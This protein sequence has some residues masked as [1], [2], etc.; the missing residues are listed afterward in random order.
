MNI[1]QFDHVDLGTFDISINLDTTDQEISFF[2][3]FFTINRYD[4]TTLSFSETIDDAAANNISLGNIVRFDSKAVTA[5]GG[6]SIEVITI[7]STYRSA[8]IHAL[9]VD[10]ETGEAFGTEVNLINDGSEVLSVFINTVE[11]SNNL[12]AQQTNAYTP[13]IG[14]FGATNSSGSTVITFHPSVTND[15]NVV[16]NIAQLRAASGG[17]GGSQTLKVAKLNASQTAIASTA[18]PTAVGIASFTT[19]YEADYLTVQLTDTTNTEYELFDLTVLAATDE[20]P[21]NDIRF[22]DIRTGG[23][24]GTVGTRR[25]GEFIVIEFTPVANVAVDVTVYENQLQ[26]DS[27]NGSPND[28]D[29]NSSIIG[30]QSGNYTGTQLDP[31]TEFELKHNDIP[32]FRKEFIGNDSEIVN[33]QFNTIEIPNHYFETGELLEYAY[34]GTGTTQAIGIVTTNVPGIGNTEYV[35]HQVYACQG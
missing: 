31:Q 19:P 24:I 30:G 22:G 26:I 34:A 18:S 16:A 35:P 3:T 15:V 14:T 10:D 28:I 20:V 11:E 2:P 8:K 7:P 5:T 25:D 21:I 9:A 13:G 23:T 6:S 27:G 33:V 29:L 1:S 4:I 32:I 17:T 12:S